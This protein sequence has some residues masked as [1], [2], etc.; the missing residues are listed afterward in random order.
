M[1]NEICINEEMLPKYTHTHTHTY[2]YIYIYIYI[3]VCVCMCVCVCVCDFPVIV[4]KLQ[5]SVL[6]NWPYHAYETISNFPFFCLSVSLSLS[7]SQFSL[8]LSPFISFGLF[9]YFLT[10]YLSFTLSIS[11]NLSITLFY[12]PLLS[13]S[14]SLSLS[15]YIYF[16][17]FTFSNQPVFF[18][19]SVDFIAP[20][21]TFVFLSNW[22]FRIFKN[23]S[24]KKIFYIL[25][26][27]FSG[28]VVLVVVVV[29]VVVY[30]SFLFLFLYGN[31]IL[32]FLN[33]LIFLSAWVIRSQNLM[34]WNSC[35][36]ATF[37]E[38]MFLL[39]IYVFTN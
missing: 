3:C 30:S 36:H 1:F 18:P 2:I 27:L 35:C 16:L 39:I 15:L 29:I 13:L 17:S 14:F 6:P 11:C 7:L 38:K 31:I 34:K 26:N 20:D 37:S 23:S 33:F 28:I 5:T 12:S 4:K 8:S 22:K 24:S 9:V 21:E 10:V 32:L 25:I 19:M